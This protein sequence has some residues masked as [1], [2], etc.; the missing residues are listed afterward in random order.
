MSSIIKSRVKKAGQEMQDISFKAKPAEHMKVVVDCVG[1][2]KVGKDVVFNL[3]KEGWINL[4]KS[5]DQRNGRTH[6]GWCRECMKK[7]AVEID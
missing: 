3:Y 4:T 7:Y 1:C 2:R 6:H 5:K